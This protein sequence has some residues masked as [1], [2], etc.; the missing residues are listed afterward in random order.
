[1]FPPCF[2]RASGFDLLRDRLFARRLLIERLRLPRPRFKDMLRL[3]VLLRGLLR[4]L[5]LLRGERRITDLLRVRLRRHCERAFALLRIP[6][7]ADR[8]RPDDRLLLGL[9]AFKCEPAVLL[10]FLELPVLPWNCFPEL[11]L[12]LLTRFSRDLLRLDG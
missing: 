11:R 5:R 7:R 12:R 9:R 1:M 8:R 4:L 3:R 10:R 2:P 6:A